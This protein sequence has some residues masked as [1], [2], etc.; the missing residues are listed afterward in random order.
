[1]M[2]PQLFVCFWHMTFIR[3]LYLRFGIGESTVKHILAIFGISRHVLKNNVP[4][5]KL[6][7]IEDFIKDNLVIDDELKYMVNSRLKRHIDVKSY[8]GKRLIMG[9]PVRGQRTKSNAGTPKRMQSR[10]KSLVEK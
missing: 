9:L 7:L 6:N 1:M 5:H 4:I 2:Q 3:F 10:Y 8:T